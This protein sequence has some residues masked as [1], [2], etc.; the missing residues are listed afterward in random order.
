MKEVDKNNDGEINF[1]EFVEVMTVVIDRAFN[2]L[3]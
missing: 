1:D 3:T 2:D